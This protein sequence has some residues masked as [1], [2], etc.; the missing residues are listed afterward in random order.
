MVREGTESR[1]EL[2]PLRMQWVRELD[3]NGRKVIR[4]QWVEDKQRKDSTA[5]GRRRF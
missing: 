1:M 3:R 5:T 4:I 2:Q